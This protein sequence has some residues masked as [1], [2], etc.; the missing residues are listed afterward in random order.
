MFK[1]IPN[2]P[3][4]SID[5]CGTVKSVYV[6]KTL[7]PRTAGKG[8]LCYQL[9]NSNGKKNEYIHRL[10]ALTFIP[11]PDNL[12]QV[13]HM[14]GDKTNNHVSNLRWVDNRTNMLSFGYKTRKINS[15]KKCSVQILAKNDTEE[16]TFETQSALL[17]HFGYLKNTSR[18]SF[19]K[20]YKYGRLKGYTLYRL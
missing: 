18:L 12:P 6:S 7:K 17:K 2:Y 20:R 3:N 11:N 1:Q 4:Y 16:I 19:N 14:D 15:S 10:V 5:E 8:Y 13:D 9:R